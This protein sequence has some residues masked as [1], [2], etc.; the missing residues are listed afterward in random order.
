MAIALP[1][2]IAARLQ[3]TRRALPFVLVAGVAEV[4]G[5]ACFVLGARHGI[6]ISAV[7][8]S[9]FG[10][11]AAVAAVVLF[12]E[13]LTR[14]QVVGIAAIAASVAVLSALQA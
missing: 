11:I 4:A 7:L 3:L 13:R 12:R 2:V 6:A 10:A 14:L 1:L 9:Q 8:A 5:F